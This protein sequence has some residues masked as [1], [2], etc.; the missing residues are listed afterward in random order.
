MNT[1]RSRLTAM[2]TLLVSILAL[3]A[4]LKGVFDEN[5]Y[6]DVFLAGSLS[7]NL[8]GGSIAQDIVT[9]PLAFIMG[10][11]SFIFLRKTNLKSFIVIIGLATYTFYAFGL[12]AIQGQYTSIYI[13]YLAIFSLSISSVVLGLLSFKSEEISLYVLPKKLRSATIIFIG[14]ML[15]VLIPV[16]LNMITSDIA[17]HIPADTYAVFLL[18]L[19]IVFPALGIILISLWY[20]HPF[21]TI[22]A[23]IGLLK[24]FTICLSWAFGEWFAPF[25]GGYSLNFAM[26]TIPSVLTLIGLVLVIVY[27]RRLQKLQ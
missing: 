21:A 19:T 15:I 6:S 25:Y 17:R 11:Q 1:K 23:G 13:V 27:L 2:I 18:D 24:A 26:T 7:E 20:K 8:I 22:L 4:S 12:Y 3:F 10:L 14:M 5:L 16:W 9:I